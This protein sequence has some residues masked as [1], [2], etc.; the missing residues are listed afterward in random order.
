MFKYNSLVACFVMFVVGVHAQ[1]TTETP[2]GYK[3]N[4]PID[5]A[6]ATNG[7]QSA[8]ALSW[9]KFHA[10]TKK[11]RFKIGYGIRFTSQFGKNLTYRTAPAILTSG[12]RG[13]QVFFSETIEK[14][15]DSLV[16]SSTQHNALNINIHLQYTIK[17]KYDIGF[18]IDAAGFT[19]GK[20]VTGKY[21]AYQSAANGTMQ[22]ASPTAFNLLLV[23]DNDLGTLNSELYFRYWL[24]SSWA[25]KA[26][27]CFLFT[28]YTTANKLR[29]ENDRWRNKSLMG[30]IAVSFSPFH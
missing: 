10:V 17:E 16:V 11:Q 24:N 19:F 5:L 15:I 25:I 7:A 22:T 27:A 18:N 26:G 2:Q 12:Q 6:F 28:E 23:S 9:T 1:E 21:V 30:L 29:L 8:I 4:T 3:Y 13:P 20:G 14:N